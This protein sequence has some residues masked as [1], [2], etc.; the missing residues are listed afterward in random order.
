M[1]CSSSGQLENVPQATPNI[2]QLLEKQGNGEAG[3][4]SESLGGGGKGLREERSLGVF[5]GGF[6]LKKRSQAGDEALTCGVGRS[7]QW[8]CV[9]GADLPLQ[10]SNCSTPVCSPFS[11]PLC[12]P[13]LLP[14]FH[15]SSPYS[16]PLQL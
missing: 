14:G 15:P 6:A 7:W 4:N 12:P 2:E 13:H 9:L 1:S 5:W 16:V 8:G 11:S 3:V 10:C